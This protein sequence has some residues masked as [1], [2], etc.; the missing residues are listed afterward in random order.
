MQHNVRFR[1]GR[2]YESLNNNPASNLLGHGISTTYGDFDSD[3]RDGFA[4]AKGNLHGNDY[5]HRRNR[6]LISRIVLG[7][8]TAGLLFS[9]FGTS[10]SKSAN[11]HN[12]SYG[13]AATV[14]QG[15]GYMS[16]TSKTKSSSKSKNTDSVPP[17]NPELE[18]QRPPHHPVVQPRR[19]QQTVIAK[20][21]PLPKAGDPHEKPEHVSGFLIYGNKNNAYMSTSSSSKNKNTSTE[22]L[23]P[24]P[25]L[26]QSSKN[27]KS[28]SSSLQAITDGVVPPPPPP[29]QST[30]KTSK[31]EI[32]PLPPPLQSNR[33]KSSST[34]KSETTEVSPPPPPP[35]QSTKKVADE[36]LLAAADSNL[37]TAVVYYYSDGDTDT[38]HLPDTLY[39]ASGYKVSY[40]ELAGKKLIVEHL[41]PEEEVAVEN[42]VPANTTTVT[43]NSTHAIFSFPTHQRNTIH[44]N[45]SDW[46][47]I[48]QAQDQLIII[49]TVATMALLVGALSARRLRS[50]HFL[51]SCIENE[52]LEDELAYDTA[53]T[54]T[55]GHGGGGYDTFTSTGS[56]GGL[57]WR[58][59]LEKFDV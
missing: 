33:K 14:V 49:S 12:P 42:D 23:P 18:D 9:L 37:E 43:H 50:R 3:E 41:P 15:N 5:G 11:L 6:H 53:Y 26:M 31:T 51:S 54:T 59:D 39:D 28:S 45:P 36:P 13:T 30:K 55:G 25:P 48:P 34:T 52:S 32:T 57:P 2:E 56:S 38:S 46:E 16:S 24:P 7:T 22:P 58:G 1:R 20:P 21:V 8:L 4:Y 19:F 44:I 27:K 17:S 10:S 35:L 40:E 47:N 29:L